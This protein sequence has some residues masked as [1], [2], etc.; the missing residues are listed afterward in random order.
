VNIRRLHVLLVYRNVRGSQAD[1]SRDGVPP[2]GWRH[3][4]RNWCAV[5]GKTEDHGDV[6]QRHRGLPTQKVERVGLQTPPVYKCRQRGKVHHRQ[7]AG[8]ETSKRQEPGTPYEQ[9]V[10]L[11]PQQ[12]VVRTDP[13]R[14]ESL[15]NTTMI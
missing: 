14:Q 2:P 15:C 7:M 12:G 1:S 13:E 10:P 9:R 8:H 4:P 6:M 5:N 11:V 3:R